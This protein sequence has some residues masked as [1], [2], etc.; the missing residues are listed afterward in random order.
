M[1]L[2]FQQGRQ[3][4]WPESTP[5]I[6]LKTTVLRATTFEVS[7]KGLWSLSLTYMLS[8][9][10]LKCSCTVQMISLSVRKS[11]SQLEMQGELFNVLCHLVVSLTRWDREREWEQRNDWTPSQGTV[12]KG[13]NDWQI[14]SQ[15]HVQT[16]NC[17]FFYIFPCKSLPKRN[18]LD[19]Q[20]TH[21]WHFWIKATAVK[22]SPPYFSLQL[23]P[24]GC[25]GIPP[26]VD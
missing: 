12:L 22:Q 13:C 25:S 8:T 17:L 14:W 26:G 24:F 15:G 6:P 20:E 2:I 4:S 11:A 18:I 16:V 21:S 19:I 1:G 5:L 3:W 7:I 9:R 10:V 23:G